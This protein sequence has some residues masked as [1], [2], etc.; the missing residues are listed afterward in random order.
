MNPLIFIQ[1]RM[2]S[3]RLPGKVLKPI[4]GKLQLQHLI[5]RLGVYTGRGQVVDR[6]S[7][8]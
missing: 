8:V 3:T 4:G 6:K 7:V 2:G 1:A 5:D